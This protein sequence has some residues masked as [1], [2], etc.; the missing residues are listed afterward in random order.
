MPLILQGFVAPLPSKASG[1]TRTP[2]L[3]GSLGAVSFAPNAPLS[4]LS[5]QRHPDS[6]GSKRRHAAIHG[7]AGRA[8]RHLV[9]MGVSGSG[10]TT[11]ATLLAERL[12]YSFADGDDFHPP[13]NVAKMARGEPLTD[14]DR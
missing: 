12:Q 9:V 8:P 11:V 1:V 3:R 6:V 10:K 5:A 4:T 7:S 14:A 13:H 2:T